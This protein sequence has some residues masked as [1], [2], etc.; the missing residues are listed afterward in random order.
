[1]SFYG[2]VYYQLID[3]F[4]K[5]IVKNSG[6]KNYTFN[7][8]LINPSETPT[9]DIIESPAVGRKG[10]FSLDSG[11]YWINFSKNDEANESAPYTI[12]HSAPHNDEETRHPISSWRL[13]TD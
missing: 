4:Y 8:N 11:N 12:W 1:M 5:I 13:E 2:S 9:K 7:D 10:V 3:T 6:N